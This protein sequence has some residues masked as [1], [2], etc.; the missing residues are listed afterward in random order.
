M[1]KTI[2]VLLGLLFMMSLVFA[3]NAYKVYINEIQADD[4]STDDINFVELIG[5]AGTSIE[6]FQI[7]HYNQITAFKWTIYI[8]SFIIPDDGITDSGGNSVGFFVLAQT[9]NVTNHD[10][11]DAAF[12]PQIGPEDFLVLKDASGNIIDAV[13]WG[14]TPSN[15]GSI[16]LTTSG[17]TTANNYLHITTDDTASDTS[18]QAPNNVLGDDGS[19]WI[20]A[21][22]TSGAINS[23][24][25]S[26]D[27]SLPITLSSF[28]AQYINDTPTLCWTTQSE[29]S[30]AGWNIYRSQTDILE[31]AMQINS[32]IIPGAGTTSEPTDYIYEDESELMENTEYWY[33]LESID[34]SGLTDSYGPISLIIPEEGEEPGSPEIPA[35]YGLHQNYPN[36]FNPNT[37]INFILKENCIA[38]LSVYNIKGEKVSTL[39]R[40]K[41][42]AKDEL[43]RVNW[44]GKDDF[45]KVVS[46]GIYLY[47]LRTNKEDFVRKMILVK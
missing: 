4:N 9:T 32:E 18:L 25:T 27:I 21:V 29:A 28:T 44:D 37:E 30:N 10:Q 2:L 31:E 46:S 1:K 20:L 19:G 39:F 40:N 14:G 26:G 3:Q 22:A 13:A 47:K 35:I 42:V 23:G 8:S 45:G 43:I 33:W 7:E 36:P 16:G 24:Q 15:I 34:Y 11:V 6:N 41:S 17:A 12:D 38:E 5:P